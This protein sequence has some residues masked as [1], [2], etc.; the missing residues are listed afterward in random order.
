M[1]ELQIWVPDNYVQEAVQ[2]GA[3]G[4]A[5]ASAPA[6]SK[7][8][9]VPRGLTVAGPT[10]RG[11]GGIVGEGRTL[12]SPVLGR[13]ELVGLWRR[14][15]W[16]RT[17]IRRIALVCIGEG[18]D[19]VPAPDELEEGQEPDPEG[20]AFLQHF[21]D[22]EITGDVVNIRQWE[23][24]I[25]KLWLT[26][27]HLKVFNE[28]SWELVKDGFG[29][30]VDFALLYGKVTPNVDSRGNFVNVKEA[31]IQQV[32]TTKVPFARDEVLRFA[33]PDIDGRFGVSDLEAIELAASTDIWA[34]IW[35]RNTFINSRLPA[36]VYEFDPGSK[37]EDMKAFN[38]LLDARVAG[39]QHANKS[40][41]VRGLDKVTVLGGAYGKD[42]EFLEGRRMGRDEMMSNVGVS[43][44]TM[45]MVTDVNRAN[46]E[47]LVQ[48]L[49]HMEARPLQQPVQETINAWRK[50]QLGIRGWKFQ[51]KSP[52]FTDE[53][54]DAET[55]ERRV[56][57]GLGTPNEERAAMGRP[58]YP[59]GDMFVM[60]SNVVTIGR[61]AT[62]DRLAPEETV[63]M[64]APAD[65]ATDEQVAGELRR[66]KKVAVKLMRQ[67]RPQRIY[68]TVV[69]P[70]PVK[71][72]VFAAVQIAGTELALQGIFDR[73]I[74]VYMPRKVEDASA[75]PDWQRERLEQRG[76]EIEQFM[77]DRAE[78]KVEELIGTQV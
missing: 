66:W 58:P 70:E 45:G 10:S 25:M 9:P 71:Q 42:A 5:K 72:T 12:A 67:G 75:L 64:A 60:P 32:G 23:L 63:A 6:P 21:F 57:T 2:K 38:D 24:P 78:E 77:V 53:G 56:R 46:L 39:A 36:A 49:Y 18:W 4:V 69:I 16:V 65:V 30:V 43:P 48:I 31:Y 11:L 34:Q 1:A 61:P 40:L 19:I 20:Q 29:N 8:V 17:G 15:N 51:F 35:N 73:V 76:E 52:D 74:D 33:I 41:V 27:V 28:C 68:E 26:F 14:V 37:D 13:D 50:W 55:A 3:P 62:E 54:K 7:D 44:G 59:G 22:P 47:G